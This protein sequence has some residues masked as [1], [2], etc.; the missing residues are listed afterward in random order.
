MSCWSRPC[1]VLHT[2]RARCRP[3]SL[4]RRLASAPSVEDLTA[5]NATNILHICSINLARVLVAKKITKIIKN[6]ARKSKKVMFWSNTEV[7]LF[8][9]C[10]ED[11]VKIVQLWAFFYEIRRKSKRTITSYLTVHSTHHVIILCVWRV[12]SNKTTYWFISLLLQYGENLGDSPAAS[13]NVA[14][15]RKRYKIAS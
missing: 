5:N 3:G 1:C 2:W 11:N 6:Y 13:L 8:C 15:S 14:I 4:T 10:A 12:Q 9:A 7:S